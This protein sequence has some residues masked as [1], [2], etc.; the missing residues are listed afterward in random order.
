MLIEH[1]FVLIIQRMCTS[2]SLMSP[3]LWGRC[4]S[5]TTVQYG[6]AAIV[7]GLG[8]WIMWRAGQFEEAASARA[9]ILGLVLEVCAV[10]AAWHWRSAAWAAREGALE[11]HMQ[12]LRTELHGLAEAVQTLKDERN[13]REAAHALR[14]A[15]DAAAD[16][17]TE[18]RQLLTL[19]ED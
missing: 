7:G 4:R 16:A 3:A 17:R 18:R 8:T 19:V 10:I 13:Q 14:L 11:R 5:N 6:L 15:I 12:D 1:L 9:F 2:M